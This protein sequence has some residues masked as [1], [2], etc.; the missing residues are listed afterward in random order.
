MGDLSEHFSL[1][2][3]VCQCGCGACV[4]DSRLIPALEELRALGPEP[5]KVLC[6]YRCEHHNAQVGGAKRSQHVEGIAADIRIAGLSLQEQYDRARQIPAFAN[7]GIGAYDSNFLHVDV[8]DGKARWA[9][10]RG[11]YVGI[12]ALVKP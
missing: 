8:R 3:F 1:S 5:I 2:E 7:G 12:S 4:V 6:G 10:Q 9:R 11:V